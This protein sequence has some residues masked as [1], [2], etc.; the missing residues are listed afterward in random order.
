[1]NADIQRL[2]IERTNYKSSKEEDPDDYRTRTNLRLAMRDTE[3][4]TPRSMDNAS[5]GRDGGNPVY[6]VHEVELV[7]QNALLTRL[8]LERESSR[9]L[10]VPILDT[11]SFLET[12]SLPGTGVFSFYKYR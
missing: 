3:G 5:A 8:L 2:L 11:T 1:M 12:Q 4:E 7:R 9:G 10:T 6:G